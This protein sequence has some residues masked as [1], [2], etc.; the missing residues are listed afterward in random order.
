MEVL[1][2][3]RD[4]IKK[5]KPN[6]FIEIHSKPDEKLHKPLLD[7][8]VQNKYSIFHVEEGRLI[9]PENYSKLSLT[10]LFCK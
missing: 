9:T 8:L 2:G 3:M 6:L 4:L 10:H 5:H 1:R 7:F